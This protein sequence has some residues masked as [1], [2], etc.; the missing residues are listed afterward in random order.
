VIKAATTAVALAGQAFERAAVPAGERRRDDD[1]QEVRRQA[2][3]LDAELLTTNV[4]NFAM[5][6]GFRAPC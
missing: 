6:R 3:M 2:D 1:P 5:L 4:R